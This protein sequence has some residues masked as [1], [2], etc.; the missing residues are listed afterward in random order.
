MTF[1][2][3]EI[4]FLILNGSIVPPPH[5]LRVKDFNLI[6][7]FFIEIS[8]KDVFNVLVCIRKLYFY[9]SNFFHIIRSYYFATQYYF[10][11]NAEG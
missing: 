11:Y 10:Y 9:R 7:T 6:T 3:R 1:G 2:S 8:I 4:P 5:T